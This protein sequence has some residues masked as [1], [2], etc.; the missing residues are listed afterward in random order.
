MKIK[1]FI[2]LIIVILGLNLNRVIISPD[3]AWESEDEVPVTVDIVNNT[4]KLDERNVL[5]K[6]V[7]RKENYNN[8][9]QYYSKENVTIN[10]DEITIISKKEEK[11]SKSYTSGLVES[12]YAYL[13]GYFEFDIQISEGNGLFP[14]I[15]LMPAD[16]SSLPEIDIFEMIGSAPEVFSGVMH[17]LDDNGVKQRS[18]FKKKVIKKDT[19]KVALSWNENELVWYIDG[20]LVHKSKFI[21][22]DYMYI[23]INQAVGGNWPGNPDDKTVFP[24]SFVVKASKIDPVNGKRRY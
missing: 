2:I 19:Y 15:W 4:E 14:A 16:K 21:S 23:I 18:Y 6:A 20:E 10:D 7:E 17:Y 22:N 11:G 3:S 8:E 1:I 5:W 12:T 13:Y 9:L 24:S